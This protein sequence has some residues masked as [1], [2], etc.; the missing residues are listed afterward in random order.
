MHAGKCPCLCNLFG[1][2]S[3]AI[4][5]VRAPIKNEKLPSG[6]EM[7]NLEVLDPHAVIAYLFN[8]CGIAIPEDKIQLF[9]KHHREVKSPWMDAYRGSDS[10]IP[11]GLYGDGARAR[12]QAYQE[13]EKVVGVFINLPLWRP[14]SARHSRWLLFSI[15]EQ[16]CYKRETMNCVYRRIVWSLNHMF[17]GQYPTHGPNGEPLSSPLA[18]T[19]LTHDRK[20]FALVEHRGDWSYF[21]WLLGFRSSWKAGVN[22]PVCFKCR[23]FGTGPFHT[24][25]YYVGDNSPNWTTEHTAVSFIAEEMPTNNPSF[26][27]T[28]F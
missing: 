19:A 8:E 9:W 4:S 5:Y 16:L 25:Y 12:Q 1:H 26:S 15:D 10:H 18:G 22:A 24:R 3:K 27:V 17:T 13:P 7:V 2:L 28:N 14:K 23:A 21:K 6:Y 20:N 11:L